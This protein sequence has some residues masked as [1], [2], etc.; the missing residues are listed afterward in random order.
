ASAIYAH[1]NFTTPL[2]EYIINDF[3]T[4]RIKL[5]DNTIGAMVVC[6]SSQ[7]AKSLYEIS[8]SLSIDSRLNAAMGGGG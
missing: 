7:Q 1:K 3:A 5:G 6:H 2:C 8:R 4:S